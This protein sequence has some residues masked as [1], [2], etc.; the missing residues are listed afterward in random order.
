MVYLGKLAGHPIQFPLEPSE[1]GRTVSF[2]QVEQGRGSCPNG[3]RQPMIE[4]SRL[5]VG[6]G[7]RFGQALCHRAL[8]REIHP[9]ELVQQTGGLFQ[10]RSKLHIQQ[11]EHQ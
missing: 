9:P 5:V 3:L 10:I 7:F 8:S 6:T 11:S 1:G 2:Q 4:G